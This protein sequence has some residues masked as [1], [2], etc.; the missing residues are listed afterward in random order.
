MSDEPTRISKLVNAIGTSSMK[1]RDLRENRVKNLEQ[2][3]G[4]DVFEGGAELDTPVNLMELATNIYKRALTAGMPQAMATTPH[5]TLR[6][7]A[8]ALRHAIDHRLRDIHFDKILE[9]TTID[10]LFGLGC[11]KV[12]V[13]RMTGLPFADHVSLD[14]LVIDMTAKNLRS[15]QWVV[16]HYRVPVEDA[17]E[18]YPEHADRIRAAA[19]GDGDDNDGGERAE[20]IT[21]GHI[22]RGEYREHIDLTDV[23]IPAQRGMLT[24]IRGSVQDPLDEWQWGGPDDGPYKFLVFNPIPDN[25]LPL[26]PAALWRS[27]HML[28]N[29]LWRKMRNQAERHKRIVGVMA[30]ADRD[31]NR[32]VESND[33]ETIRLDHPDKVKEFQTGG[34]APE[35][36]GFAIQVKDIF[37]WLAG[38]LDAMGGLAPQ[39]ETLGQDQILVAN[40]SQRLQDMQD[41]TVSFVG[42]ILR[43][44]GWYLWHDSI[45]SIPIVKSVDGVEGVTIPTF[46]RPDDRPGAFAQYSIDIQPYSLQKKTPLQQ[47]QGILQFLREVYMPLLPVLASQGK[48]LDAEALV[49]LYARYANL[50]EL[51]EIITGIPDTELAMLLNSG[52]M[53]EGGAAGGKPAVTTR[54]Y[55]RINRPGATRQGKDHALMSLFFGGNVQP[56]ESAAIA[57]PAVR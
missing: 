55:E 28:E 37:S 41:K 38:N 33:G 20:T 25:P 9:E 10:A 18:W 56:A 46:W 57:R 47:L 29:N 22:D 54:R 44:F 49:R 23:W 32:I 52:S 50:P 48:T 36:N 4:G 19:Q 40:A 24:L 43:D 7:T 39:S 12:A 11:M 1:M 5:P 42:E 31:A 2:Y 45:T 53:S 51:Y 21:A 17:V 8:D 27:L 30:G 14:D 15:V 13:D 3:V 26:P 6:P 35:L 16:N 34:L